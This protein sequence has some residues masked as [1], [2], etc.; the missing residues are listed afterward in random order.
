MDIQEVKITCPHCGSDECFESKQDQVLSYLCLGCGFTSYSG[1]IIDSE[2]VKQIESTSARIV[3]DLKY[4]DRQRNIVWYPSVISTQ[5]GMIYPEGHPSN[6]VWK[7]A[8]VIKLNDEERKNYPV[9]GKENEFYETALSPEHALS[10][11][12]NEF[13]V[14]MKNL[15]AVK[16][17]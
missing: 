16:L 3:V 11:P 10:F 9:P 12:K 4:Y 2:H 17:E 13:L 6:W 8:R 7:V 15:G 1:L 14:A 5:L